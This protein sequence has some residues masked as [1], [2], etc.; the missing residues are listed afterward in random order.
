MMFYIAGDSSFVFLLLSKCNHGGSSFIVE[1]L[2]VGTVA[3][4]TCYCCNRTKYV[5][6]LRGR[7][8]AIKI[9][10]ILGV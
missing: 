8:A 9:I 7:I 10:S 4:N 6:G 1:A 2:S 5:Y 3:D